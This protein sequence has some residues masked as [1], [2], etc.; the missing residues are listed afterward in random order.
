MNSKERIYKLVVTWAWRAT[1]VWHLPSVCRCWRAERCFLN[2]DFDAVCDL[3]VKLGWVG[4]GKCGREGLAF[5]LL[6]CTMWV[7][8][9]DSLMWTHAVRRDFQGHLDRMQ[10]AYWTSDSIIHAFGWG[11]AEEGFGIRVHRTTTSSNHCLWQLC[12]L[13]HLPGLLGDLRDP[14]FTQ[15]NTVRWKSVAETPLVMLV[16]PLDTLIFRPK[17]ALALHEDRVYFKNKIKKIRTI[18][19]SS[20]QGFL[21]YL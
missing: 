7:A 2:L 8:K 18:F 9:V 17:Q 21:L 6:H 5:L 10:E 11:L 4:G 3:S 1:G 15:E 19:P 12:I 14:F 16:P 20:L 13:A